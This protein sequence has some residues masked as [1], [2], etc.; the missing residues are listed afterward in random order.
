[1]SHGPA[2]DSF[3]LV[4]ALLADL[5]LLQSVRL[6]CTPA[7]VDAFCGLRAGRVQAQPRV[8]LEV[9]CGTGYVVTSAALLLQV[10]AWQPRRRAARAADARVR[11]AGERGVLRHGHQPA[12]RCGDPCD[13]GAA[14]RGGGGARRLRLQLCALLSLRRADAFAGHTYRPG[15]RAGAAS[16]R[17]RRP[18][19]VQP[20]ICAFTK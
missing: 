15:E 5:P 12:R 6:P 14:W 8:C 1:M 20:A 19:A 7:S 17:R 16:D 10:R 3:A 18:A 9:G 13:A 2:Q 11:G 4:D